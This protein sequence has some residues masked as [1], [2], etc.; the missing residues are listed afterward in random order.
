[1]ANKKNVNILFCVNEYY[2]EFYAA[3][4]CLNTSIIMSTIA[5]RRGV[6]KIILLVILLVK[7]EI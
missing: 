6:P 1:M 7:H 2:A 3:P 4:L 5:F